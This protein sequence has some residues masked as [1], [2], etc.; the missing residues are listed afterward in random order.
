L[1]SGAVAPGA[2][3]GPGDPARP[4]R[5]GRILAAAA[6]LLQGAPGARAQPPVPPA[7][8]LIPHLPLVAGPGA[9]Y[10]T[11]A[12]SLLR[13]LDLEARIQPVLTAGDT[14]AGAGGTAP[15][16]FIGYAAGVAAIPRTDRTADVY[17]AHDF[18]W[19]AGLGGAVVSRLLL[20]LA[21]GGVLA[22]DYVLDGSEWYS[23]LT[24]AT[25]A[26]A[27]EGFLRP[28]VLL[29]EGTTTGPRRG[30]VA[31]LDTRDGTL[32][33]LPWLG[34]FAHRALAFVPLSSGRVAAVLTERD[35]PRSSQLYLYLADSDSDFL[36]GRGQLYVFRADPDGFQ[37]RALNPSPLAKGRPLRGHFVPIAPQDAADPAA[38]ERAAEASL[39]LGFVRPGGV[40]PDRERNDAFY[41]TDSG[42]NTLFD[43]AS[44]APLTRNG[45]LYHVVLDPFDP[46]AVT[47][48]SVV[49][50]GSAED[51]LYRPDD[52]AGDG[53]S[54]IIQENPRS[55]RGL[56]VARLIR[57]DLRTR[58][59]SPLAECAERDPRGRL[60]P[61]GVGGAWETH[62][63]SS[64]EGLFGPDTWL[65]AVEAPT[66]V[67]PFFGLRGEG[68][69]LLLLS[70]PLRSAAGE[71]Q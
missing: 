42:D 3:R 37:G 14:L 46:T 9:G 5:L 43:F 33:D 45:R 21:N 31:A 38:L 7:E 59:L 68:G 52:L 60:L 41:F 71:D 13:A 55:E 26:G 28:L 11:T 50:D 49:L 2:G 16:P 69:Q 4:R 17:V 12:A 8:T 63:I 36:T 34:R 10:R 30:V 18:P 1:A 51:D 70:G 35:V 48:L 61:E 47:E 23:R 19:T 6:L 56:H 67:A 65:L 39:A 29:G 64:A 20:D 32:R 40:T 62:G 15:F 27:R 53:R 25:A 57:Y 24:C 44:G 54:L 58:R 22:A 66:I